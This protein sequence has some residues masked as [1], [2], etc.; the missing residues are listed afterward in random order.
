M[1]SFTTV[2][3]PEAEGANVSKQAET[4]IYYLISGI[5]IV[6][7]VIVLVLKSRKKR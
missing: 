7:A 1:I 4:W 2:A 5:I 3:E 6:I